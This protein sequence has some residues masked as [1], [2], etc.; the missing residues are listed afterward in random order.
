[1]SLL[2]VNAIA[3]ESA[4]AARSV[5]GKASEAAALFKTLGDPM[6]LR[7]LAIIRAHTLA[8]RQVCMADLVGVMGLSQPSVSHHMRILREAGYVTREKV[9][10]RQL[11]QVNLEA[12]REIVALLEELAASRR[13][14]S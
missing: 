5:S 4:A 8:G 10:S 6:R 9:G 13:R 12:L 3:E 2:S 11:V 14:K 1:M 7:M